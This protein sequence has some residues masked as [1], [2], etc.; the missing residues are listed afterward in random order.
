MIELNHIYKSYTSKDKKYIGKYFLRNMLQSL[1]PFDKKG[2]LANQANILQDVSFKIEKGEHVAVVGKNKAGKTTLL[3]LISG[4]TEPTAG[5]MRVDGTI[6]PIFAQAH[7]LGPDPTGR[8]YIYLH[9]TALGISIK[10]MHK[11]VQEIIDFSEITTIDTPVKFY[12]TGMRSRLALSVALHLPADIIVLDEVF[13]GSDVFFKDKVIEY[14]KQRFAKETITLI[15]ISHNE[16]IVKALCNRAL[17]LGNGSIL[18]DGN[19]QEVFQHYNAL[20][21]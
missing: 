4:I 15:M 6:V 8:E 7:L 12:S 10:E 20:Y 16:E 21:S 18:K 11:R 14:L 9:G 17:L 5:S 13:S 2:R 3:Q 1:L 19:P